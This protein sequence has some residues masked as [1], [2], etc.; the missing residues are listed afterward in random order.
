M[1]GGLAQRLSATV[2]LAAR[3]CKL[4]QQ[5]HVRHIVAGE[6]LRTGDPHARDTP[7]AE[8]VPPALQARPVQGGAPLAIIP[9]ALLG[10][11]RLPCACEMEPQALARLIHGWGEGLPIGRR[12]D[13]DGPGHTSPP[14][15]REAPWTGGEWRSAGSAGSMAGEVARLGPPVAWRR[16]APATDAVSA[17]G[18]AWSPPG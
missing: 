18:V 5:N 13:R 7:L 14:L 10:M 11:E 17:R 15:V 8:L 2:A 16:L 12:P 3:A 6:S 9:A 4:L 1:L